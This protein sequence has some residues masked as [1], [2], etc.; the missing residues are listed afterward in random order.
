MLVDAILAS[1]SIKSHQLAK[2]YSLR[3]IPKVAIQVVAAFSTKKRLSERG[4][5]NKTDHNGEMP[6][7]PATATNRR[8]LAQ[9]DLTKE[10]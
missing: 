8:L 1:T 4:I 10:T 7:Y 9:S 3:F 2:W 6:A 5:K